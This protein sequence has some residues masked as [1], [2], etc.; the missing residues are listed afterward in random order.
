MSYIDVLGLEMYTYW[1]FSEKL[2]SMW[3]EPTADS[4]A[5]I[6]TSNFC[7][8]LALNWFYL[9]ICK[10][11]NKQNKYIQFYYVSEKYTY[12]ICNIFLIHDPNSRSQKEPNCSKKQKLQFELGCCICVQVLNREMSVPVA[13]TYLDEDLSTPS[14]LQVNDDSQ[15]SVFRFHYCVIRRVFT[16]LKRVQWNIPLW[17]FFS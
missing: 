4:R 13:P 1:T 15:V 3:L 6:R 12:V 11:E 5:A 9:Y 10:H 14:T 7:L 2:D 16:V 17:Q 8:I